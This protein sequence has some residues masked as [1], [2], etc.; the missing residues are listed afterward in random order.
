MVSSQ[1]RRY[2]ALWDEIEPCQRCRQAPAL[3]PKLAVATVF[4]PLRPLP[5]Q[6]SANLPIRFLLVGAE[7][8]DNWEGSPPASNEAARQRIRDGY[9]NYTGNTR[10]IALHFAAREWLIDK[11]VEGF[12]ITDLA[13]CAMDRTLADATPERYA[14]CAPWLHREIALL[15]PAALIAV[16]DRPLKYLRRIS[17]PSN[18]PIFKVPHFS[19]L[20]AS[21]WAEEIP[22]RPRGIPNESYLEY[23]NDVLRTY[24][25]AAEFVTEVTPAIT[26][27]LALYRKRFNAIRRDIAPTDM[28]RP[29][30]ASRVRPLA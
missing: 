7:P 10:T 14:I 9:R 24:H 20:A 1:A 21:S 27:L 28:T 6:P 2:E 12:A 11:T 8:S 4:V 25:P 26:R 29:Y 19:R 15:K 22:M 30:A 5:P 18:L 16:G 13:K 23:A 3:G 17:L